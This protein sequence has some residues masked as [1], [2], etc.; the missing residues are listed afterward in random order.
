MKEVTEWDG[1]PR[2]MWV[3]NDN[4]M[5]DMHAA[6]VVFVYRSGDNGYASVCTV[7]PHEDVDAY[8]SEWFRHC[9]EIEDAGPMTNRELA[10]WLVAGP[11][12]EWKRTWKRNDCTST[13]SHVYGYKENLADEPVPEYIVARDRDVSDEWRSPYRT[14][15]GPC[16][17]RG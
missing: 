11:K 5:S 9:A 16:Y 10:D 6:H 17:E 1:R 2:D 13:V 15:G 14:V 4:D 12:R 7:R 8:R 3:W